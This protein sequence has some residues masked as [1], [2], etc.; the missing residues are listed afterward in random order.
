MIRLR[1]QTCTWQHGSILTRAGADELCL[2]CLM[3]WIK[4]YWHITMPTC[5]Y[6]VYGFFLSTTAELSCCDKTIRLTRLKMYRPAL[7]RRCLLNP[8]WD[9]RSFTACCHLYLTGSIFTV[10]AWTWELGHAGSFSDAQSQY[11]NLWRHPGPLLTCSWTFW[12]NIR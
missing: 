7:Y 12:E 11:I 1:N 6:I 9:C 2:S 3:L 8:E 5:L 10:L 4:F